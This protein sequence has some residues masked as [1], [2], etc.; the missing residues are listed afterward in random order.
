MVLPD[1]LENEF[2][3]SSDPNLEYAGLPEFLERH[4]QVLLYFGSIFASPAT[5]DTSF[6]SHEVFAMEILLSFRRTLRPAAI[7]QRGFWKEIEYLCAC[8]RRW[9]RK[10]RRY[11][12]NSRAWT[13]SHLECQ[14][15]AG[16]VRDSTL[17]R[18]RDCTLG[19]LYWKP[20]MFRTTECCWN[21]SY[22]LSCP[23]SFHPVA[24]EMHARCLVH[25]ICNVCGTLK[26][27][28]RSLYVEL[29]P[30]S[31]WACSKG[32]PRWPL[33]RCAIPPS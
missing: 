17:S 28:A 13:S 8:S 2:F 22:L 26:V 16:E 5:L 19:C 11:S 1:F 12:R 3:V 21:V 14:D 30:R 18:Q 24:H 29:Q 23:S 4:P 20:E 10:L 32:T 27:S 7:I 25:V 33:Q 31:P 15:S 6:I 9:L